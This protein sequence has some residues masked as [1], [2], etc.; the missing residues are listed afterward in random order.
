MS[1]DERRREMLSL[2]AKHSLRHD[3]AGFLLSSGKRSHWYLDGKTALSHARFRQLI[4][5]MI[6]ERVRDC[7]PTVVGGLELGSYPIATAVSDALFL[8]G[9][10]D[11]R[12]FVVRKQAKKHGLQRYIE[13]DVRPNDRAI[14][15]DDVITT[16]SSTLDAFK[17]AKDAGLQV[18]KIVAIVDREEENGR[19]NIEQNSSVA[20]EAL[21]T[22]SDIK[23]VQDNEQKYPAG[24]A[25]AD[26]E[27]SD[28]AESPGTSSTR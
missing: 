24:D 10:G 5:E 12:A 6:A 18:L 26:Q 2:L 15:V 4:G 20:F 28:S 7:A 11:V 13:G 8:Q 16:G 9:C 22:L 3:S 14:I 1:V 17:H 23:L 27:R 21:C 25:R 19:Q